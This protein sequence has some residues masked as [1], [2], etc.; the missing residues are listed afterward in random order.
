MSIIEKT[1]K[2][3]LVILDHR[4][5]PHHTNRINGRISDDIQNVWM[6]HLY[7]YLKRDDEAITMQHAPGEVVN[8]F[9]TI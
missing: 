6:V 3:Y 2:V 1:S 5:T 4:N 8:D 7:L 9:I